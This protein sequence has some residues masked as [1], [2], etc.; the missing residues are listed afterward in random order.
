M[1]KAQRDAAGLAAAEDLLGRV[2][3][4]RLDVLEAGVHAAD[5]AAGS[6]TRS[7]VG[8]PAGSS[9][10]PVVSVSV[11]DENSDDHV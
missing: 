6:W 11:G 2:V 7:S 1:D 9:D 10:P 3:H 4:G 5:R 8:A